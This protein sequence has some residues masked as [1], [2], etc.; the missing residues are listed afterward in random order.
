MIQEGNM[1][2]WKTVFEDEVEGRPVTIKVYEGDDDGGED[3]GVV[4]R[5]ETTTIRDYEGAHERNEYGQTMIAG[6][7]EA[8]AP[9]T[10][11]PSVLDD[12]EEE[13]REVGFSAE[14][15]ALIVSKVPA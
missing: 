6:P 3:E 14:A 8:G 15:A 1:G 4:V 13:L 9:I 7:E 11:E 2:E 10:V 12:L 5:V